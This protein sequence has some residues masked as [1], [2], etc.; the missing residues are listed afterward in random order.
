MGAKAQCVLSDRGDA[1]GK[2]PGNIDILGYGMT[3]TDLTNYLL[4]NRLYPIS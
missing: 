2:N 1:I 4:L 3:L